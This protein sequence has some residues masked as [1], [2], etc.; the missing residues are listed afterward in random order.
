MD[1]TQLNKTIDNGAYQPIYFLQGENTYYIDDIANKLLNSV[2]KEAEK[3]FNQ[4]ILYGK[5]TSVDQITD[6]AKRYPVMSTYQLIVVREAQH[7]NNPQES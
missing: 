3:D 1:Y 4:T 6:Y 2:L 5:D 7:L